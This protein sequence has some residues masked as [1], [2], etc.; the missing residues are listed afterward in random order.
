MEED[1]VA[2]AQH[3]CGIAAAMAWEMQLQFQ[4]CRRQLPL[5]PQEATHI[6]GR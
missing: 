3:T 6:G 1:A 4:A 2:T 5:P